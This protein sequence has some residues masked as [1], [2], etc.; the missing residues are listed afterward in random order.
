[1]NKSLNHHFLR[2][3]NTSPSATFEMK[4]IETKE[5]GCYFSHEGGGSLTI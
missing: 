4:S 3:R 2:E 5:K 1:M